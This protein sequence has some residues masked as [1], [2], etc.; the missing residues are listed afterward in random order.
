MAGHV[1]SRPRRDD[2]GRGHPERGGAWH[3][4]RAPGLRLHR[5]DHHHQAQRAEHA[6]RRQPAGDPA[7]EGRLLPG[8]ARH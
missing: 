1:H 8:N 3:D 4:L 7:R 2:T 6:Q 5:A